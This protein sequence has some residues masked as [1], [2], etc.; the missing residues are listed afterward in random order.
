MA[1]NEK[2]KKKNGKPLSNAYTTHRMRKPLNEMAKECYDDWQYV[3]KENPHWKLES[4][5]GHIHAYEYKDILVL[6][7][8][9]QFVNAQIIFVFGKKREKEKRKKYIRIK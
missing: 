4:N 7:I 8:Q 2:K 1:T 5:K 3:S 9:T 6:Y